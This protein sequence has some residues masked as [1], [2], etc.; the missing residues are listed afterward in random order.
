MELILK[1]S[2]NRTD[3]KENLSLLWE[4]KALMN[5]INIS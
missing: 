3:I 5:D 2:E 1:Y 4:W